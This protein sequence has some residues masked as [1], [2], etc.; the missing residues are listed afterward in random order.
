MQL[1]ELFQTANMLR[2]QD[3]WYSYFLQTDIFTQQEEC[4]TKNLDAVS[5][6]V[7]KGPARSIN[8]SSLHSFWRGEKNTYIYVYINSINKQDQYWE[9]CQPLQCNVYF[10]WQVDLAGNGKK[11]RVTSG[12]FIYVRKLK[13]L[14]GKWM[15]GNRNFGRC[16]LMD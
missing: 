7:I 6:F 9:D 12:V 1:H 8:K 5:T 2:H 10:D 3:G 16:S 14:G 4:V 13:D 11:Y 15:K